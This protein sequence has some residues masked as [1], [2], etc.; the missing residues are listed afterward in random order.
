M[1]SQTFL[2]ILVSIAVVITAISPLLLI[3]LIIKDWKNKRIW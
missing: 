2:S 3:A 1:A